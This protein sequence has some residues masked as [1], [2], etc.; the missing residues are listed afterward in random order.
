MQKDRLN[1]NDRTVKIPYKHTFYY[2][3]L[4]WCAETDSRMAEKHKKL[5]CVYVLLA[6]INSRQTF[7]SESHPVIQ[8]IW[9]MEQHLC[10]WAFWS[11]AFETTCVHGDDI[12]LLIW[13][14]QNSQCSPAQ[15]TAA[16]PQSS[17]VEQLISFR[18]ILKTPA[19]T[20]WKPSSENSVQYASPEFFKFVVAWPQKSSI[21]RPKYSK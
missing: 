8:C 20:C 9:S 14:L 2:H 4:T 13:I 17:D 11:A 12:L 15:I 7:A 18:N 1:N 21:N 19:L 16:K 5:H 6:K 3:K 10:L